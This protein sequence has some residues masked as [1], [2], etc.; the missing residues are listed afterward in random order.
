MGKNKGNGVILIL[1]YLKKSIGKITWPLSITFYQTEKNIDNEDKRSL[2][3]LVIFKVKRSVYVCSVNN[4]NA[5]RAY[6]CYYQLFTK[7][8]TVGR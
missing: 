6:Q 8:D 1:N 2:T 5:A 7:Y 4:M 3:L